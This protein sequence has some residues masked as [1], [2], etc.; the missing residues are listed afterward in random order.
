ME[1]FEV[2]QYEWALRALLASSMVGIVCGILGCFIVLR[3]M[4]LIGDA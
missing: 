4:A 3:N 2:F 1:F